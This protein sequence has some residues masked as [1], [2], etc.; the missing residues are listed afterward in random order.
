MYNFY[1]HSFAY[2]ERTCISFRVNNQSPPPTNSPLFFL[3]FV[4]F[5]CFFHHGRKPHQG[6]SPSCRS[7]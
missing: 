4:G 5:F 7:L 1:S 2:T 3:F 6:R